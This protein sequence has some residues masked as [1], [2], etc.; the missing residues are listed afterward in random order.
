MQRL[1]TSHAP[2]SDGPEPVANRKEIAG[3]LPVSTWKFQGGV[4]P[5]N[6]D[7]GSGRPVTREDMR[8]EL[9][10]PAPILLRRRFARQKHVRQPITKRAGS[11]TVVSTCARCNAIALRRRHCISP[12]R[13]ERA[14]FYRGVCKPRG[15]PELYAEGVSSRG[16]QRV[17]DI[18][19]SR[20]GR[21][22]RCGGPRVERCVQPWA[23]SCNAFG[24]RQG[25]VSGILK[26]RDAP[27]RR[28]VVRF[29]SCC[30]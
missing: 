10:H 29:S 5:P 21:L 18:T 14:A 4:Y 15:P 1:D 24:V 25:I 27:A 20:Y 8:H 7:A 22:R 23:M 6:H 12:P 3:L 2:A 30:R 26:L 19:A 28:R 9:Q 11:I 16:W 13:V 17:P